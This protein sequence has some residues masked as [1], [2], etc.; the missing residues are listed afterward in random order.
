MHT[1]RIIHRDLKPDNILIDKD[2]MTLKIADLG[3][4]HAQAFEGSRTPEVV[5]LW[6]R[7]PERILRKPYCSAIDLWS[8]GLII[9][10]MLKLR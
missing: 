1:S 9:I 5:T 7:A 6:Y 10:E 4:A 3:L 8:V 2:T